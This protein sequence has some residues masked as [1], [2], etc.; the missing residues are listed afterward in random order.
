M[1]PEE[2]QAWDPVIAALAEQKPFWEP[3]TAHGY[4]A[5]T[6][7]W[8]VGEVVRRV[9]G[10]SLGT[11]FAEE[12]ARPLGLEFWIGLPAE[13]E[14]RVSP[15][16]GRSSRDGAGEGMPANSRSTLLA[17]ALNLGGAFSDPSWVNRRGVARS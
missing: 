6:Y 11:Y 7:G 10:R 15:I 3:G 13:Q 17:R 8:L 16:V 14:H 1:S 2:V 9:S 12:I 5:L 4:H